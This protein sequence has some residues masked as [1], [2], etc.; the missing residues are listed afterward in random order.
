MPTPFVPL[1]RR[2]AALTLTL[3]ACATALLL[4]PAVRAEAGPPQLPG[5]QFVEAWPDVEF[6][7]PIEVTHAKDGSDMLYVVEQKGT[8][9]RIQ[10]YRGVGAVPR[11]ALFLDIRSRVYAKS[12]GGLLSMT[13]HPQFRTNRLFYVS[14]LAEN[15]TPGPEDHKFK[16]VVAEYRSNGATADAGSART[17]IEITKKTAQHQAGGIGFG[18]DGMLYLGIGDGNESKDDQ[19]ENAQNPRKYLGKIIRIDPSGRQAGKGYSIPAGNPWPN[20]PG[21][22]P[23]IWGFGFRNPWRFCWDARGRMWVTE[24]GSAGPESREWVTEVRYGGNH[25]WP[26]LEGNRKLKNPPRPKQFVPRTF[27]YIRGPE[28][29]TA[30]I[31]GFIY[32][33]DRC[34]LMRGKY[35]FGDYMRGAV[36]CIDLVTQ[37]DRTV[38]QDFRTVGDV[39]ELASFGE[40]E[41][42]E[43]YMCAN[44]MGVILT[45]TPK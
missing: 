2:S 45:I 22:L 30:G 12:Q 15:A 24:P 35:I 7:E 40:D 13:F 25:G 27:E 1:A 31:G 34:K 32:R 5:V 10:K 14:Y 23:E 43:I 17:V 28:G 37:G 21:V 11:P 33:G 3:A 6:K 19:G 26:Y 44:E 8:V 9:Q 18:P 20:T 38:G 36:Y 29:S 16:L 41:Q 42:G 39:P 4:L